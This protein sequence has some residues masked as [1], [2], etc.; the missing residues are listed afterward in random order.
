MSCKISL[1][2]RCAGGLYYADCIESIN[3]CK[4]NCRKIYPDHSLIAMCN[5]GLRRSYFCEQYNIILFL[6]FYFLIRVISAGKRVSCKRQIIRVISAGKRV[7]CKRQIIRVISA[8]KRVS[9]KRQIIRVISAGKRVSCKRQI[10]R[11]ISAGKRVSCKRQIIRVISAGK[12]VSC[13]RQIIRVISAGK[14]VSCKR[15]ISFISKHLRPTRQYL[16]E[17]GHVLYVHK[18]TLINTNYNDSFKLTKYI[19]ELL[20]FTEWERW[21]KKRERERERKTVR[22][23]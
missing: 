17:I 22:G 6:N 13:K 16:Y 3:R 11:V 19:T 4:N 12:R 8:G 5:L 20:I 7:S 2:I 15:Q 1:P 9:C 18:M 10:I 14:R 23:H 21:R